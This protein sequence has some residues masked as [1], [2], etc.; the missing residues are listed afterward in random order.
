MNSPGFGSDLDI[1]D[2]LRSRGPMSVAELSR[3]FAVTPTAIRQ[4]LNRLLAEGVISR[5]PS[6]EGR[7]RPHYTYV[8]TSKG[9]QSL[10]SNYADLAVSLWRAI[11]AIDAGEIRQQVLQ[12]AAMEMAR[13]HRPLVKGQD[14]A[15]RM[16]DV[17]RILSQKRVPF[18]VEKDCEGTSR[19][20]LPTD[21][22]GATAR[23]DQSD[24]PG[25][26][27]PVLVGQACPYPDLAETDGEICEF[28]RLWLSELLSANV[29]LT[30]CRRE[31][32]HQCHFEPLS[33]TDGENDS[34]PVVRERV[35][36]AWG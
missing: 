20:P 14:L 19:Q 17:A 6:R 9:R 31:G 13:M 2:C 7:G 26:F 23:G 21:A 32:G 11:R 12:R 18:Y 5:Q 25:G 30:R 28:E 35:Q 8:I 16:A 3:Q 10:G 27:L 29:E 36:T 34:N 4:R 33:K 22:P 24:G 1:L 15:E